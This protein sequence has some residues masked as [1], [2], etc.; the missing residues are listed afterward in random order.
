MLSPLQPAG[1]IPSH[2]EATAPVVQWGKPTE[3]YPIPSSAYDIVAI[4]AGNDHTLALRSDGT[5]IAWGANRYGQIDVPA[6]LP[7][8]RAVVAGLEVSLAVTTDGA[9]RAWGADT[10][11]QL[12][13][14]ATVRDVVTIAAGASNTVVSTNSGAVYTI[15]STAFGVRYTRTPTT[16]A[17]PRR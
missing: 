12:R 14:P 2:S 9:I 11:G 10:H 13:W 5:V 6:D 17:A 15:G 8:V 1:A 16:G 7:P 4:S 3:L